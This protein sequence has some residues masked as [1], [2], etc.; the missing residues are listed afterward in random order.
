MVSIDK[1]GDEEVIFETTSQVEEGAAPRIINTYLDTERASQLEGNIKNLPLVL[2]GGRI[3]D[4]EYVADLWRI[5]IIV[6]DN[7]NPLEENIPY[8]GDPVTKGGGSMMGRF[9]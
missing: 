1:E 6:V 8:V 7:N 4:S 5:G 3:I 2:T 9:G